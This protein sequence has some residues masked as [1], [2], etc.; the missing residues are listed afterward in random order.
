[1][2]IYGYY[3][4][5]GLLTTFPVQTIEWI[6]LKCIY[7]PRYDIDSN[8]SHDIVKKTKTFENFKWPRSNKGKIRTGQIFFVLSRRHQYHRSDY[9]SLISRHRNYIIPTLFFYCPNGMADKYLRITTTT[10][11][12][13][14]VCTYSWF[15]LF[16]YLHAYFCGQSV[17]HAYKFIVESPRHC[18]PHRWYTRRAR[19]RRRRRSGGITIP[20][21]DRSWLPPPPPSV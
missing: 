2:G 3:N 15:G 19:W 20:I 10:T 9:N 11:A 13:C 18:E 14:D 7:E 17:T 6:E 12:I 1:M 5:S 8:E 16:S 4:S 21:V